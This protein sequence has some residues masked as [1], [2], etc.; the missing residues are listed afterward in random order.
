MK[1]LAFTLTLL[2]ASPAVAQ[3][4]SVPQ[5]ADAALA[6]ITKN[7]A[8]L[9]EYAEQFAMQTEALRKQVDTLQEQVKTLTK[10]RDDL[11]TPAK[12]N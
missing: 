9:H 11:K 3:Q 6:S 8:L 2:A 10:E 4:Q 1:R 7:G 12:P 5:V